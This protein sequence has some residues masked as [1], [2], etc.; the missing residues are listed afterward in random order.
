MNQRKRF[1]RFKTRLAK[2]VKISRG[3]QLISPVHYSNAIAASS[4]PIFS[5][6]WDGAYVRAAALRFV[7]IPN[8]GS[9]FYGVHGVPLRGHIEPMKRSRVNCLTMIVYCYSSLI[10]TFVV[11]RMHR[12]TRAVLHDGHVAMKSAQQWPPSGRVASLFLDSAGML[13][14]EPDATQCH[15]QDTHA[16]HA[17]KR[18]PWQTQV[19]V[20]GKVQYLDRVQAGRRMPCF[21]VAAT[22]QRY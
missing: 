8:P 19:E 14:A 11:D 17:G 12:P 10:S 22:R 4:V 15:L 16:T 21:R 18:N 13:G 7:R 9:G 1:R 20:N 5:G 3:S 2:M 6:W